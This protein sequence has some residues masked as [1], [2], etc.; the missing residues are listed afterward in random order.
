[1]MQELQQVPQKLAQEVVQLLAQMIV[2]TRQKRVISPLCLNQN[3]I[4]PF[5]ESTRFFW[6]PVFSTSALKVF[7]MVSTLGIL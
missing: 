6:Y 2:S 5:E 3:H 4:L 1:M 7:G